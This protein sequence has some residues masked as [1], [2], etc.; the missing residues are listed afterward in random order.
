M[1]DQDSPGRLQASV[2]IEK[3]LE[4]MRKKNEVSLLQKEFFCL[5][6]ELRQLELQHGDADMR[7]EQR[8]EQSPRRVCQKYPEAEKLT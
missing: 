5:E 1:D 8:S 3:R 4:V 7:E 2:M 6:S